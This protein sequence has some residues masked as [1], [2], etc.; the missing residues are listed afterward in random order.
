M[1]EGVTARTIIMN[2]YD[3]YSVPIYKYILKMI[4]DTY[5][6]EDLTQDTFIRAYKYLANKEID[7]PKTFLYRIAHNIAIDY[8]RKQAPIQLVKNIFPDKKDTQISIETIVEGREEVKNM[9][10]TLS[11]LKS[12]YR[13]VIILRKIEGFSIQETA[14]I[15]DWSESK[16]KSTLFRAIRTLEDRLN[17]GG[18]MHERPGENET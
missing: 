17:K 15:L 10:K 6:A 9:Y 2:W 4:N 14:Q 3:Q 5:Q 1:P 16:V 13:Q 12:S 11:G 7:Y 8:I 18:V